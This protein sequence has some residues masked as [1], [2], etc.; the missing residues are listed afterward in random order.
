MCISFLKGYYAS[1]KAD[2]INI[3]L[4][5]LSTSP[6]LSLN[7]MVANMYNYIIIMIKGTVKCKVQ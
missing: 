4:D 7:K 1:K 3:M 5:Y 2:L 6:T